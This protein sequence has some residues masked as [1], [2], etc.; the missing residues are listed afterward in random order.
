MLRGEQN[1][2]NEKIQCSFNQ[3]YLAL[4]ISQIGLRKYL[5]SNRG[6]NIFIK[7]YSVDRVTFIVSFELWNAME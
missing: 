6:R 1:A 2:F 7:N 3:N 4:I 5:F